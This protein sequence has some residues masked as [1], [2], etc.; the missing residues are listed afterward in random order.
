MRSFLIF[1]LLFSFDALARGEYLNR[2]R[3]IIGDT[4]KRIHANNKDYVMVALRLT[5]S[6]QRIGGPKC[7]TEQELE[8]PGVHRYSMTLHKDNPQFDEIFN[9]LLMAKATKSYV[10]F[11][12]DKDKCSDKTG[13]S[14]I[15]GATID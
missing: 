1:F 4:I 5:T 10:Y 15:L 6:N 3:T 7:K 13:T 8:F 12:L 9:L 2:D 11:Y 14:I